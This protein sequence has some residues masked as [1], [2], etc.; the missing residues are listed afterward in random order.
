MTTDD[1]YPRHLA[2][3]QLY[4]SHAVHFHRAVRTCVASPA[5]PLS[6]LTLLKYFSPTYSESEEHQVCARVATPPTHL[7]HSLTISY[8]HLPIHPLAY[9]LRRPQAAWAQSGLSFTPQM[10]IHMAF[11]NFGEPIW[12][13]RSY[14]APLSKHPINPL[15][16]HPTTS[17]HARHSTT[18][19]DQ[20]A[21]TLPFLCKG[22]S[23]NWTAMREVIAKVD[24]VSKADALFLDELFDS[25]GDS[26]GGNGSIGTRH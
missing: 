26:G 3:I 7:A 10:G 19:R 5:C 9:P 1:Y 4:S 17:P 16:Y 25:G 2:E 13:Q 8:T 20:I 21:I 11:S 12:Y 23:Q 14:R 22:V 24:L 18:R 15:H 6:N